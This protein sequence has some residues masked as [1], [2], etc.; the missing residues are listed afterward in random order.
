MWKACFSMRAIAAS[1]RSCVLTWRL[2]NEPE[3]HGGLRPRPA[4]GDCAENGPPVPGAASVL[5]DGAAPLSPVE[6]A[7]LR[8]LRPEGSAHAPCLGRADGPAHEGHRSSWPARELL[9][10]PFDGGARDLCPR[11][12]AGWPRLQTCDGEVRTDQGGRGLRGCADS[13]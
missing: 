5:R 7:A 1:S 9:G 11:S 8:A 13:L 12:R 6:V 10:E 4:C 3:E 2:C